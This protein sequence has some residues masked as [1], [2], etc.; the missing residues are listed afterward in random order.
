MEALKDN[1]EEVDIGSSVDSFQKIL[2]SQKDLFHSQIDQLQRIVVAQCKLTGVNPLSQEMA[3]GALS[4]N[5]G[6]RPRDLINPKAVNYMQAVFSI[7]D[8]ISKKESREINAQFGVTV[9]QVREFFTSQRSRVRKLV[10]LSREKAIKSVADKKPQDGVPASSDSDRMMPIDPVPLNSVGPAAIEEAPSSSTQD[11]APP[12]LNDSDKHFVDNIFNMLRK[13]ETFSGQVKMMEWIMQIKNPPVIQ[14]FLTKGGLMILATWL[15]QAAA[16]EQTSVLF[17]SLKVLDHLPLHNALPEHMSAILH[18]INR[19]RFYRTPDISNRARILLAKWS[20]MFA[21]SQAMKKPNGVKSSSDMQKEIL[22]KQS[23]GDI[24]S[25]ELWQPNIDTHENL[26]GLSHESSEN[27]RKM[28]SSQGLKLL[29]AST[30]D[31]SRKHILGVPTSHARERRK[32]QM[33]EQPGHNMAG[34]SPQA[35]RTAPVSQGRPM[36]T[37]D[38]QKAKLRAQHMQSKY[39]KTVPS[40]NGGIGMKS[41]G[42]N[43]SSNTPANI[44]AL[45]SKV[46]FPSKSEEQ[47]KTM[48]SPPNISDKPEAPVDP[49]PKMD[50]K[51]LMWEKCARVQI[52]WQTPPEIKLNDL[53]RVGAGENSK[54]VDVQKN[55]NHREMEIIYRTL[56]EIPS[57][58]KGPW[59]LEMDY[60]D[61]LTPEIPIEQPPEVDAAETDQS[62]SENL[63]NTIVSTLSVSQNTSG[64]TAEPDLE[65][66]AVLLKNPELVFALSSGQAANLSSEE[67][68]KLL[69]LIKK[70]GAGLTGDLS[71]YAGKA[72]EKVEVSLPSPTP[73]SNTGMSGWRPEDVKNRYPQN[74][75]TLGNRVAFS[76]ASVASLSEQVQASSTHFPLPQTN[77]M[78]HE[79]QHPSLVP[80][81][82]PGHSAMTETQIIGA[83][84]P[85]YSAAAGPS[86]VRV[87]TIS[88]VQ[89][90]TVSTMRSFQ[91]IEPVSYPSAVSS[92]PFPAHLQAQPQLHHMSNPLY[93]TQIYSNRTP[94]GNLGIVP[95][96][97]R[98]RQSLPL[99][100]VTEVNQTNYSESFGRQGQRP[101]RGREKYVASDGFESW[102]PENSPMRSSDYMQ[103]ENYPPPRMNSD[104]SNRV[105]DRSR[106]HGYS[107]H[108]GQNSKGDGRWRDHRRR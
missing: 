90:A 58:P 106:Q 15:S 57:N 2:N 92:L 25:D 24:M 61:S 64:S 30:D 107:G 13:E 48:V 31:S 65:L 8:A 50:S 60:D 69:D 51:E 28:E 33:V 40:S 108:Q 86:S 39:G 78:F 87:E 44:V 1:L 103:G 73:S 26:L 55:R 62:Q 7:K 83:S 22:L 80:S 52:P 68:V 96:S 9:T 27:L 42:L 94:S 14:W 104:W 3:A 53:W 10:W 11:N 18:S 56:Q 23:I 89:P 54:E 46:L 71:P 102:S 6:K 72:E 16:E 29:P 93:S 49:K 20:K 84:M 95:D 76:P 34:R 21:R 97:S 79:K 35:T 99:N 105:D 66:L 101:L 32:V 41:E 75:N 82:Y 81:S 43:N 37:D 19:L 47:K 12:D 4:I 91:G 45:V 17:V 36:S 63:D 85:N 88:N 100:F 59:D 77:I 74:G 70:G 98:A 67:V 38:I 5:I